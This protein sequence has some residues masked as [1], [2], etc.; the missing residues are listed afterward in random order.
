MTGLFANQRQVNLTSTIQLIEQALR[1][2]EHDPAA[3]RLPST[4]DEAA[5]WQFLRGSALTRIQLEKDGEGAPFLR[6]ASVVMTL[7]ERVD[8]L[9]LFTHLLTQNRS[10]CGLTLGLDEDRVELGAERPCRDL[11]R[12]EVDDL[13]TRVSRRADELD[14]ELVARFGGH[15]GA[16]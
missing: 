4:S 7:D 12:S 13:L 16:R 1:A 6:V 15:R 9:A 10:L 5:S 3:C 8:R 2:L 14:D 11:D